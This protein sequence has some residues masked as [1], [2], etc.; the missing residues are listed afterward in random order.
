[1]S[2]KI[3][4]I[5]IRKLSKVLGGR[6]V[7]RPFDL[8]I[9]EGESLALTGANGAGKTTLLRCLASV[10]RPTTGEVQWF[11]Q[12]AWG[13]PGA[14]KPQS[15]RMIALV[16]HESFLYP[17]LTLRENL[18]FAARM[19]DVPQPRRRADQLLREI[20]LQ[21]RAHSLAG[22]ISK[23][24][25]QRLA[26]ARAL[27]H[28]PP[29]I[30]LDEPFAGLDS[31]GSDWLLAMLRELHSRRRTICF[32]T[33]DKRMPSRLADRVLYLQSG[34]VEELEVGENAARAA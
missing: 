13:T 24:M 34:R 20:G 17:H 11:G 7:L 27:V 28:D 18:I 19:C 31:E 33:H 9:A 29:I 22:E 8:D 32:S 30:L 15:R 25:R 2:E 3:I 26:V 5:R 6:T 1:M 10:L 23:G 4:A 16:A 12:P 14:G 21:T